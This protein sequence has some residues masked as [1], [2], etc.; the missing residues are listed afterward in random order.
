MNYEELMA[1][2][3]DKRAE[4][5]IEFKRKTND[6]NKSLR[7]RLKVQ[8]PKAMAVYEGLRAKFGLEDVTDEFL[9]QL[10]KTSSD[11]M[12][13][14]QRIK[15]LETTLANERKGSESLKAELGATKKMQLEKE[16]DAM[17]LGELAKIGV[18]GDAMVDA[19]RIVALE[20]S[21]DGDTGKWLFNG[22]DVSTYMATFAKSKP[23]W[24]GNPVKGG[25]GNS[26]SSS[27]GHSQGDENFI[28][29]ADYM[30]LS[31]AERQTPEIRKKASYSIDKWKE[32]A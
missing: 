9:D 15:A 6:E 13:A 1:L 30:A 8:N 24:I 4:A 21:Y 27:N 10:A 23:Y 7:D 31:D 18:R 17:I 22:G 2:P 16:R 5:L 25:N 28:S 29:E 32:K 3:E 14:E 19:Q 26:S 11:S 12:T 20:S